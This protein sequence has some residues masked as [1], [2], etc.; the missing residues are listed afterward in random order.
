M[1]VDA[2]IDATLLAAE[3]LGAADCEVCIERDASLRIEVHKGEV[4]TLALAD[5]Q[6]IG[7]RIFTSDHRM[8]FASSSR[9]DQDINALVDEAWHAALANS[10][11]EFGGLIESDAVSDDDWSQEDF[12][13]RPVDEKIALALAIEKQAQTAHA[14][15]DSVQESRYGD[16]WADVTLANSRGLR[17]RFRTASCSCSVEIKAARDGV[18][19]ETGWEFDFQRS[20]EALKPEWVASQ[21][22]RKAVQKL[23]GAPCD[24]ARVPLVL[25]RGVATQFLGI[26]ASALSGVSVLKGKSLLADKLG[27][28]VAAAC[29]T[30]IDQ[31]DLPEGLSRSPFDGEGT[32]AQRT[33]PIEEGVLRGYL[34][35]HYSARRMGAD[36]TANA[37][38]GGYAS[39]PELGP[40]NLHILP[41][42]STRDALL[43]QAGDGLLVTGAM[44]VHTANPISGDFSFGA[45]GFRIRGGEQAEPVRGVTIAGNILEL[46]H[47]IRAVG[48]DIRFYGATGAPSLLTSDFMVSGN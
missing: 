40:T 20:F 8:G 30:L 13:A 31:N 41:G 9:Q 14:E 34:H 37:R 24:T 18:D 6:G 48:S 19:A 22:V 1:T 32:S 27:E 42:D 35:N 47:G 21:G 10:P 25:D 29:I 38:R 16:A 2:R 26:L 44:G 23:G 5:S 46:F 36:S 45:S 7:V 43:Q 11:D 12:E 28:A 3:R 39:T 15:V 17:R 4:E 33:V